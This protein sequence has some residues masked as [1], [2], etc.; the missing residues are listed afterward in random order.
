MAR[1]G[2]WKLPRRLFLGGGVVA[3][4]LPLL[5]AMAPTSACAAGG[6][7]GRL[8]AILVPNGIHMQAWTPLQTGADFE[9]TPILAPLEPI[10]H[11]VH[12]ISG[13]RNLPG[14]P[15]GTGHHTSGVAS[16]L[17]CARVPKTQSEIRNGTS[18][19][20]VYARSL[21]NATPTPS[22]RLG[23]DGESGYCDNGY[24]CAYARNISWIDSTPQSKLTEPRD[25][26][27]LLFGGFD[28]NSNAAELSAIRERR[29]SVLDSALQDALSLQAKLGQTDRVKVQEYLDSVRALE[30]RIQSEST[31]L[32]CEAAPPGDVEG[33]TEKMRVMM[34]LMVKAFQCDRTRVITFMA[35]NA[36]SGRNFDFIGASGNHHSI[37]HHGS[38]Q[39]NF[40]KLQ[41]INTWEI[42]QFAYLL[43]E[44]D[45]SVEADGATLLDNSMVYLASE[46]S[47]GNR[48]NMDNLPVL[49][50]GRG[51]GTLSTTGIHSQFPDQPVSN[52]FL[53]MLQK[54]GV[55]IDSFG[56]DS[57]APLAI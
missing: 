39:S 24:S 46:I 47:D 44:L 52:L 9:L 54:Y 20:Q 35:G 30:V 14:L 36:V 3:I 19:D 53:A 57:T 37:S 1:P 21:G 45:R 25:A 42:E 7:A 16:F 31:A 43:T 22:I 33:A 2:S 23:M 26:F 38:Q 8:L 5:D 11:K 34:D 27:D 4:G 56:D 17:T 49:L 29:R 18:M 41:I 10:R 13:L 28:P 40:D 50:A 48:H 32:A 15:Y 6:G 12:V 51:R 55:R